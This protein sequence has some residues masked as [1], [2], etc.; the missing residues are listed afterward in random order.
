MNLVVTLEHRFERTPDGRVWTRSA[1]P[2]AYWERF[3]D[4]FASVRA[5]ARVRDAGAP[6]PDWLRADGPRVELCAVPHYVGPWQYVRRAR[7][8]GRAVRRAIGPEDA[9]LLRLSSHLASCVHA[10]LSRNGHPYAV[11][12]GA[13]PATVYP[14]GFGALF[15]RRM[16]RQLAGASAVAYVTQAALQRRYPPPARAHAVALSDVELPDAAFV[17]EPRAQDLPPHRLISVGTLHLRV[18]ANDVLLRAV[19]LAVGRGL[20][21]A[22]TI[23]GDGRQ[24][25]ALE[26]LAGRLGIRERVRFAGELPSGDAVRSQL[27][28]ADLY[29]IPSRSEGLPR[30]LLEAMARGLAC[31]GSSVGGIP[32]LLPPEDLVPAGDAPALASKIEELLRDPERLAR[33]ARRNL[34]RARAFHDDALRPE[35]E[36]FLRIIEQRTSEWIRA[37]AR[38]PDASRRTGGAP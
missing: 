33:S 27:D 12:V 32:E 18:K 31:V 4:T 16:R 2:Y 7:A 25:G 30:S 20:D 14:F 36:R 28:A 35:R 34:E 3:L 23:V 8:V 37:A 9:V 22:L 6:G 38:A 13:D 26:R 1:F 15:E 17:R 19:A 24:R 29:V 21:L 11:E 5:V 10:S